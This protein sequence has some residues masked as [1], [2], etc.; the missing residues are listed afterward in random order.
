MSYALKKLNVQGWLHN[1]LAKGMLI[2]LGGP[3]YTLCTV[4]L[5]VQRQRYKYTWYVFCRAVP[6]CTAKQFKLDTVVRGYYRF[7]QQGIILERCVLQVA[8][9]KLQ[10]SE[11]GPKSTN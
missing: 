5:K 8:S 2:L 3:I 9:C 11:N 6:Q 1:K 10:V 4:L 7:R